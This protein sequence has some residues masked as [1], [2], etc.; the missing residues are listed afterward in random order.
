[1]W[2]EGTLGRRTLHR[3]C[4]RDISLGGSCQPLRWPSQQHGDSQPVGI[5]SHLE[6]GCTEFPSPV[7]KPHKDS[8]AILAIVPEGGRGLQVTSGIGPARKVHVAAP[9]QTT[10]RKHRCT[11]FNSSKRSNK[12][13]RTLSPPMTFVLRCHFVIRGPIPFR[14]SAL[15]SATAALSIR[16]IH[17]GKRGNR[18]SG[19]RKLAP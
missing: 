10:G 7:L 14:Q 18:N 13:T 4:A 19:I 16:S 5:E 17:A 3:N 2:F 6:L 8:P 11:E 15:A 9:L 1:M 12:E